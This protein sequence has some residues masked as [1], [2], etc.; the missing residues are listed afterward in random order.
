MLT[1]I[2]T[3]LIA[4]SANFTTDNVFMENMP[5]EPRIAVLVRR[6]EGGEVSD[7]RYRRDQPLA[8]RVRHDGIDNC[9]L[10]AEEIIDI[11]HGVQNLDSKIKYCELTDEIV[12]L[13][14]DDNHYLVEFNFICVTI[15]AP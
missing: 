15:E 7:S 5:E 3:F 13:G 2:R 8:I 11:L 9:I 14:K 6:L 10:W 1:N 12:N 4:E